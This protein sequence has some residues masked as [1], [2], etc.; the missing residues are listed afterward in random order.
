MTDGPVAA[1]AERLSTARHVLALTGAG[2][3]AESGIPTYRGV[4][5]LYV[6]DDGAEIMARLSRAAYLA[7][8]QDTF[9]TL[10]GMLAHCR[11]AR[12]NP[13]HRALARLAE[14]LPQ[15]V[16]VTQ[17]VDGLHGEAGSPDVVELHGNLRRL[18]CEPCGHRQTVAGD[19]LPQA[20]P[21]PACEGASLRHDVVLFDELLPDDAVTRLHALKHVRWDVCLLIG[22]TAMFAYIQQAALQA[23]Q[24]GAWIAEINPEATALSTACDRVIR[25]P[26]GEVLAAATAWLD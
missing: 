21:C 23:R 10:N 20:G 7:R 13:A 1:L 24:S 6:A 9:E 26:A 12:P 22:T 8:P 17:N 5:G 19:A 2:V 25:A 4:S 14:A 18:R 15:V 16:V 11:G 3:S